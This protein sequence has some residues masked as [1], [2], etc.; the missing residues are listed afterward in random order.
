MIGTRAVLRRKI[1]W[2]L[3]GEPTRP[4]EA[5]FGGKR[6]VVQI[7]DFPADHL[8]T[9]IVEEKPVLSFDD[10]PDLWLRPAA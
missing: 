1:Q 7:N 5:T 3:T 8:Y 10:W 2:S 6:L 4:F 9:L